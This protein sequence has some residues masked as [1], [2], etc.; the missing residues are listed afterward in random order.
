[1][2]APAACVACAGRWPAASDRIAQLACTTVHLHDDR[3]FPGWT[4]LVLRCHA[5]VIPRMASDPR[6]RDPVWAVPHAPLALD[7][8]QRQGRID[9]IRAHLQP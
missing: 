8:A 7:S 6:L 5:T 4:V 2:S 3:F 9:T 1:V